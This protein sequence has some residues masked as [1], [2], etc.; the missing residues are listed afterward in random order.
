MLDAAFYRKVVELENRFGKP[1]ARVMNSL[2]TNAYRISNEL[3]ELLGRFRF[4]VGVS[5]DGP[6]EI[7]D[8]FRKNRKGSGS[9]LR[10][11][12]GIERLRG[13]RVDLNVLVAVNSGN[14][15]NPSGLYRF[16]VDL[17][18][19]HQQYIPIVELSPG[20]EPL[21]Y[22]ITPNQWGR[23]LIG[24]YDSWAPDAGKISIRYFDA[25][26]DKLAVDAAAMCSM[27]ANCCHYFV[28]EYNGDVFPC[29]F[30]VEPSWRVG[31]IN[32]SSWDQMLV[33][34]VYRKFGRQKS[35]WSADCEACPYLSLCAGDC[36]KYRTGSGSWLCS[37][38]RQFFDHAL[39]GFQRLARRIARQRSQE[40]VHH[41]ASGSRS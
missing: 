3:A 23:F 11:L 35:D 4:L 6:Q 10:T 36:L 8:R 31:N 18:I 39:P 27:A 26:I 20:G 15:D 21:P 9:Y 29:D 37:G 13:H 22:S 25:L 7:H 28:V 2:Q 1:G 24:L 32:E 33:S 34:A 38:Y 12:E 5:L 14:V 19:Q 16:L 17:G 41:A 30:F 40:L